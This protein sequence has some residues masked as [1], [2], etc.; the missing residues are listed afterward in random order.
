MNGCYLIQLTLAVHTYGVPYS[1]KTGNP[2]HVCAEFY[3]EKLFVQT[4]LQHSTQVYQAHG[5]LQAARRWSK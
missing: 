3:T 2:G 4:E 5:K 1:L